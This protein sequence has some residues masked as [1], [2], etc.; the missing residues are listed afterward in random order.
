MQAACRAAGARFWANV[1]VA[2]GVCPSI[3][4]YRRLYG[5]V[6]HTQ[7]KGLP[8]RAV[9][10]DRL[11]SKL[12]LAAEYCERIVSWGYFQHGRPVLGP[13]ASA[14]YEGYR[15]YYESIAHEQAAAYSATEAN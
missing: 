5:R 12:R 8:W 6:H 15:R 1:E 9:P 3:D 7:A 4:E 10:I 13:E 11:A 2:E 14:W